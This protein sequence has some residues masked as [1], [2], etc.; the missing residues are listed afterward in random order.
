MDVWLVCVSTLTLALT[1]IN[2]YFKI[3][4]P[5]LYR[6]V[7]TEK[8][9]K[10]IVM[11]AWGLALVDLVVIM[12]AGHKFQFHPGKFFCFQENELSPA[13]LYLYG[14]LGLPVVALL[15]CYL[16]VF[17]VWRSRNR[18]LQA[19]NAHKMRVSRI[20]T[21][22]MRVTKTLFLTVVASS[23]AGRPFSV[24]TSRTWPVEDSPCLR[25]CMLSTPALN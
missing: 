18:R 12:A 7:F 2:R 9:A 11:A 1:A 15:F 3:V 17:H 8:N 5:N 10:V 21:E 13:T 22:D 25:S 4:R 16:K 20:L 23:P 19:S 6:K 14:Y 24:S